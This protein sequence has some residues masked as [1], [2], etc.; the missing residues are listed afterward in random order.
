[1]ALA[2]SGWDLPVAWLYSDDPNVGPNFDAEKL[3]PKTFVEFKINFVE[4]AFV[5]TGGGPPTIDLLCGP[6]NTDQFKVSYV[7]GSGTTV[8]TF[9]KTVAATD[10]AQGFLFAGN[11]LTIPDGSAVMDGA[12]D[13]I[14][15]HFPSSPDLSQIIVVG[16]ARKFNRI[17]SILW[18]AVD[19]GPSNEFK[20]RG[21][22]PASASVTYI[23][24]MSV[25]FERGISM[26]GEDPFS[27]LVIGGKPYA[28]SLTAK[29]GSAAFFALQS[30]L[31]MRGTIYIREQL[32]SVGGTY[33]D[34]LLGNALD[35]TWPRLPI[36]SP[37]FFGPDP[38]LLLTRKR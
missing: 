10:F 24:G 23:F 11:T 35:L 14:D 31:T 22:I 15:P 38:L 4:A 3:P 34:T 17:S 13:D 27:N 1:M 5:S 19:M 32:V 16:G 9:R 36:K 30:D 37:L 12:D 6:G 33:V 29:G 25:A 8:L 28:C 20:Y 21:R 7:S 18:T 26:A 2:I